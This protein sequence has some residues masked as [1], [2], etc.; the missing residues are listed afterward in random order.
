MNTPQQRLEYFINQRFKSKSEFARK[1]GDSPQMLNKYLNQG[2]VFSNWHKIHRL[3]ELGLNPEWYLTGKGQMDT[4]E[5]IIAKRA[6]Q[7]NE[8]YKKVSSLLEQV[9][10]LMG[11]Y[12]EYDNR[13]TT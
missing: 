9:K 1:M 4:Q 3:K 2:A 12:D 8:V 5:A 13:T 10:E 7:S 11:G 6:K